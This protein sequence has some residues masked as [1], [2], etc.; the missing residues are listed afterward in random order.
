[1]IIPFLSILCRADSIRPK[2]VTFRNNNNKSISQS[3]GYVNKTFS[4]SGR[5]YP[6]LQTEKPVNAQIVHGFFITSSR[7]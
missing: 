4:S 6:P 5:Y 2:S 1:M 3:N 7:S